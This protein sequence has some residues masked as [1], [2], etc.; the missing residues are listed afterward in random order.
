MGRGNGGRR[1]STNNKTK[2]LNPKRGER[3]QNPSCKFFWAWSKIS[4]CSSSTAPRGTAG[5]WSQG[6]H[7]N[8][9]TARR[10][11]SLQGLL[12]GAAS[13]KTSRPPLSAPRRRTSN[14]RTTGSQ[15]SS[16]LFHLTLVTARG[17]DACAD[18]P[19]ISH[20]G[21]SAL[22]LVVPPLSLRETGRT[23][24]GA[25]AGFQLFAGVWSRYWMPVCASP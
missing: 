1:H 2:H 21:G 23:G 13:A 5:S 24:L 3:A 11:R 20:A 10:H 22:F 14:T 6:G 17:E 7:G 15:S 25:V 9:S 12:H 4:G 18:S 19:E 16:S 8:S